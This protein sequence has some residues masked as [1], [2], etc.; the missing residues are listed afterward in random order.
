[1]YLVEDGQIVTNNHDGVRNIFLFNDDKWLEHL[2]LDIGELRQ[3]PKNN[4]Y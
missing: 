2:Q 4:L 1:M 3:M